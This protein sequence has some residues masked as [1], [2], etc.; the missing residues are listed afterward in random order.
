MS[1][2]VQQTTQRRIWLQRQDD[3]TFIDWGR[4]GP[5]VLYQGEAAAVMHLVLKHSEPKQ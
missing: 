3:G 2:P 4:Q 5:A 1:K